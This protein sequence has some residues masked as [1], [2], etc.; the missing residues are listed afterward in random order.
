MSKPKDPCKVCPFIRDC[1]AEGEDKRW[2]FVRILT[3]ML[4]DETEEIQRRKREGP[5]AA[6]SR[7]YDEDGGRTE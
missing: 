3:L 2:C 7:P 6:D 1:I 5:R 4:W